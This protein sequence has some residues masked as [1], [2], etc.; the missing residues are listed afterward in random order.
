MADAH[1]G[2]QHDDEENGTGEL[3]G[4]TEDD[5]ALRQAVKKLNIQAPK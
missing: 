4:L 1:D 2:A 5:L 3:D